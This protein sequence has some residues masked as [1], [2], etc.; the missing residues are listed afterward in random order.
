MASTST[1]AALLPV[2]ALD[3]ARRY[4]A[5]LLCVYTCGMLA[6]TALMRGLVS[7]SGV[8]QSLSLAGLGL[9][10]LI[11]LVM[12]VLMFQLLRPGLPMIDAELRSEAVR[13]DR[14]T[15]L[16]ERERRVVDGVALAILPF[17]LFYA[18]W[19]L[20]K[21]QYDT[22]SIGLLNSGGVEAFA[23]PSEVTWYGLPLVLAVSAWL[24]RR[25]CAH[26]YRSG[27]NPVL[28]VLTALFEGVWVFMFLFSLGALAHQ[29]ELWVTGRA[30]WAGMRDLL[31]ATV[32][33]F[34]V[35]LGL[36]DLYNTL[37]TGW[38]AVW[39]A[40]KTGFVGPVLWLTIT[41]VVYRAEVD[42]EDSLFEER[43]RGEFGRVM[44]R[45]AR[46]GRF[47][48]RAAGGDLREQVVPCLNA[49]RFV[50]GLGAVF[51]LSFSLY[52]VLLDVAFSQL[53]RAVFT[54]VGPAPLHAVWWPWLQPVDFLVN[55][56]HMLLRVCLLAAAFELAL[57]K[58]EQNSVGRR[59]W[60]VARHTPVRRSHRRGTTV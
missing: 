1:S 8:N 12:F 5:P 34:G 60:R 27:R 38:A 52:F 56:L 13:R 23:A 57:R 44:S 48:S 2:Y 22:Y 4:W 53:H 45:T 50:L 47:F 24:L 58:A 35:T 16:V 26:F 19:G 10:L 30:A 39:K 29:V 31:V 21:E 6:H 40:I 25:L 28:G 7:L 49:L 20:I 59:A 43:R 32:D 33:G 41:A 36:A 9:T 18:A 46:V 17:L 14:R 37:Q 54:L 51:Y 42:D 3:L 55:A 15:G 11:T